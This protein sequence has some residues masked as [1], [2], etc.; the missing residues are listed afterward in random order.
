MLLPL[1]VFIR[2]GSKHPANRLSLC[3]TSWFSDFTKTGEFQ[4]REPYLERNESM[5]TD[6][7]LSDADL[8]SPLPRRVVPYPD[9]DLLSLLRRSASH[10]GYPDLRWLLRP[11]GKNWNIKETEI[12]LLSA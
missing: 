3:S 12:P 4:T 8:P 5:N 9:E 6:R 11:E 7:I 2:A 1:L 10:M